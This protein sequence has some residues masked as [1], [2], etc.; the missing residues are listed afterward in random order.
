MLLRQAN[1]IQ[2]V[3]DVYFSPKGLKIARLWLIVRSLSTLHNATVLTGQ[4]MLGRLRGSEFFRN[5]YGNKR[6]DPKVR[7]D[8][9]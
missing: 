6:D 1:C 8:I 9:N 2:N 3:P 7:A 5:P 4:V